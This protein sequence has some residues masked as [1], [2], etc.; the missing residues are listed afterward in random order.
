MKLLLRV[1][2]VI[3]PV[4]HFLLPV[5]ITGKE[6]NY[7]DTVLGEKKKTLRLLQNA[8]QLDNQLQNLPGSK[9]NVPI[10]SSQFVQDH[11]QGQ[12]GVSWKYRMV[13][14]LLAHTLAK[15]ENSAGQAVTSATIT[16]QDV[17]LHLSHGYPAVIS[18]ILTPPTPFVKVDLILL[19]I[20]IVHPY[21][22]NVT[23]V[24]LVT[25]SA[26]V[27]GFPLIAHKFM[28]SRT[29]DNMGQDFSQGSYNRRGGG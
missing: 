2:E 12:D 4:L 26:K 29:W 14:S 9:D 11:H 21:L 22:D 23:L 5:F 19:K 24:R 15:Q 6:A 18:S 10:Q 17:E 16:V 25:H 3:A 1:T 8:K 27:S 28:M 13:K 7:F 20:P